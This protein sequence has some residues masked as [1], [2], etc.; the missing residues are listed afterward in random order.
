VGWKC[1]Y[2]TKT[3]KILSSDPATSLLG[4][5]ENELTSKCQGDNG[6][7]LFTVVLVMGANEGGW[8]TGHGCERETVCGGIKRR[9]REERKGY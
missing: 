1:G 9:V 4:I 7:P 2:S 8:I 5:Y 3:F 6:I